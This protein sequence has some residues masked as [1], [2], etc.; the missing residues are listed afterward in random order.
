M[1]IEVG[2]KLTRTS[3]LKIKLKQYGSDD[4]MK[5]SIFN[6]SQILH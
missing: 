5:A 3:K 4:A 2:A 6:Q 1:Q